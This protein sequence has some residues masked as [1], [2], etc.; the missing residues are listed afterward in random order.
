MQINLWDNV[1]STEN[2][3]PKQHKSFIIEH[4]LFCGNSQ[5]TV[6]YP[7]YYTATNP[8]NK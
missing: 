8:I 5:L 6:H 3:N 2:K 4:N 1:Q 7:A